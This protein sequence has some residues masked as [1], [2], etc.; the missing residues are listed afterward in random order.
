MAD[1]DSLEAQI[2][3][4]DAKV[5]ALEIKVE[6][7]KELSRICT[8]CNGTGVRL[9]GAESGQS[10]EEEEVPCTLCNESGRLDWGF[11]EAL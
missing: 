11:Q 9:V 10:Y 2:A 8:G 1:F 3:A 7:E 5:D 4:L 6:A